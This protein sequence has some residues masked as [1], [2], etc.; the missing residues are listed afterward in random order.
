[1]CGLICLGLNVITL[2]TSLSIH[3]GLLP[4]ALANTAAI[5]A[6]EGRGTLAVLC[7]ILPLWVVLSSP[8]CLFMP[9]RSPLRLCV[10]QTNHGISV[11]LHHHIFVNLIETSL[12]K[13]FSFH[14]AF[15]S[16]MR[17]RFYKRAWNY[18]GPV[19]LMIN[20][21]F[22]HMKPSMQSWNEASS[23]SSAPPH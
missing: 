6:K 18:S 10:S 5:E 19:F 8:M 20:D 15:I 9:C 4:A 13:W 1:M 23:P 16:L 22:G 21:G 14:K 11:F 17:F 7:H 3:F 2:I 12:T